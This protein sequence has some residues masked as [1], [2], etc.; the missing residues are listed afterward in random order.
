MSTQDN[1]QASAAAGES[2]LP[3]FSKI[4]RDAES[5]EA[6]RGLVGAYEAEAS[7]LGDSVDF[8]SI[9]E[10]TDVIVSRWFPGYR[11]SDLSGKQAD[12]AIGLQLAAHIR[13]VEDLEEFRRL[14]ANPSVATDIITK[15][16]PREG[17]PVK[18]GVYLMSERKLSSIVK[19]A[20][21]AKGSTE[22]SVQAAYGYIVHRVFSAL[23]LVQPG[24][25]QKV[26]QTASSY[27][28]NGRD[29]AKVIMIDGLRDI[30][31]EARINA[32]ARQLSKDATP[33]VIADTLGH[34]FRQISM[35]IPE[36]KL[37]ML[38]ME[39]VTDLIHMFHVNP[40]RLAPAMQANANLQQLA[41]LANFTIF[42]SGRVLT[43]TPSAPISE[44]RE[45]C[46]A[47]LGAVQAAPSIEIISL[48]KYAECFG[49]VPGSAPEGL[50]RGAVVYMPLAQTSKMDI[51]DAYALPDG[52]ELQ[53]IPKSYAPV[54]AVA[55]E[56]NRTVLQAKTM[57]GVANLIADELGAQ[58]TGLMDPPLLLTLGVSKED[59]LYIALAKSTSVAFV[60]EAGSSIP[61]LIFAARVAEQWRQRVLAATSSVAF[62]ADPAS[63]ITY[64]VGEASIEPRPLPNR[65]QTLQLSESMETIYRGD[66]SKYL[67]AKVEERFGMKLPMRG[68]A[69]QD[70]TALSLSVRVLGAMLGSDGEGNAPV[71]G[72]VHYMAVREPGVDRDLE[73]MLAT[74]CG[75]A[76]AG[77]D[78]LSDRAKSWLVEVLISI[79]THPAVRT[80]AERAINK[81]FLDAK[82]DAR[83]RAI[84][85][86]EFVIQAAFGVAVAVLG[87]FEKIPQRLVTRL[88]APGVVPISN[89]TVRAQLGLASVQSSV[90]SLV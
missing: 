11:E 75:Y 80:L 71:R 13:R 29:M 6:I 63:L 90:G 14:L 4:I 20:L 66:L 12:E 8:V 83:S 7:S 64:S 22:L 28:V 87:Q 58:E 2:R 69:G 59:L 84:Q 82:V 21:Q 16:L 41:S 44:Q 53:M 56:L 49:V 19:D 18:R 32:A 17:I 54:T 38:Q 31:S 47:I 65:S 61:T 67:T 25:T 85:H 23:E 42:A 62:F 30:L 10:P 3:V 52:L 36:I 77:D 68:F 88:I 78:V 1:I 45:A 34:M 43:E 40:D 60:K 72:D 37:K 15:A 5:S 76:E 39:L 79:V 9:A 89:L 55:S 46:Q 24:V 35:A 73:L 74:I 26:V 48:K 27:A 86:R 51:V 81:A 33:D 50:H 70:P 57:E